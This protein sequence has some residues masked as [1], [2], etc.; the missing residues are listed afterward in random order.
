M[1]RVIVLRIDLPTSDVDLYTQQLLLLVKN[2]AS[3]IE[4]LEMDFVPMTLF[5]ALPR[6]K[7]IE[8]YSWKD[9]LGIFSS[10]RFPS[11]QHVYLC[12]SDAIECFFP[13][14]G[15]HP[16]DQVKKISIN[17]Y[18]SSGENPVM[19]KF[20]VLTNYLKRQFPT[21]NCFQLYDMPRAIGLSTFLAIHNAFPELKE[22]LLDGTCD[23]TSMSGMDPNL[24]THYLENDLAMEEIPR[25]CSIFSFSKL[26]DLSLT[27]KVV[28]TNQMV[29]YCLSKIPSLRSLSF[30]WNEGL[31]LEE[32]RCLGHLREIK[33]DNASEF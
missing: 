19:G 5:P 26:E 24:F 11:L 9:E 32:V 20:Y 15:F 16:H 29:A 14:S 22:I 3:T 2:V 10:E 13:K 12:V 7:R 18:V 23:F 25:K 27:A 8:F 4:D 1:P 28:V 6:L 21:A 33:I 31:S 17:L 30:Q